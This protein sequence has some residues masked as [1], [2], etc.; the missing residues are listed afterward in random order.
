MIDNE[1]IEMLQNAVRVKSENAASELSDL[2]EACISDLRIAGVYVSDMKDPLVKQAIKLYSKAN[3]GYDDNTDRYK[4][5][6]MALKDAMAL[7][8]DY[9]KAADPNE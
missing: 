8:G 9:G 2:A 7:S 1:I 4:E 6:Y 5:S 3:F